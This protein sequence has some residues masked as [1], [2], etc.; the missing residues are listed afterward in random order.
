METEMVFSEKKVNNSASVVNTGPISSFYYK[1]QK[2]D[3]S[4]LFFD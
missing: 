2:T 3:F 1:I 4:L